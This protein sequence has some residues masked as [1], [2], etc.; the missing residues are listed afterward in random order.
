MSVA[1]VNV[2]GISGSLRE[3]S[4]NTLLLRHFAG[5]LPER[6]TFTEARIGDLPLFDADDLDRSGLPEPALR[7]I[8]QIRSAQAVVFA[9]PEYNYSVPGVLK[10]A[11]DWVSREKPSPFAGKAVAIMSASTSMLGGVRAQYHL[12]QIM[13]FLDAHPI[14]K[15]EVFLSQAPQRFDADGRLIDQAATG[16]V[17]ELAA[18][19]LAWA[20]QLEPAAIAPIRHSIKAGDTVK[21]VR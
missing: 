4:Y 10:N 1:P 8:A 16:L 14:N 2:L 6:V 19:L 13:V 12:R 5:S 7:L 17:A 11:I 9:T 3:K 15:P 18:T 20:A 21:Q